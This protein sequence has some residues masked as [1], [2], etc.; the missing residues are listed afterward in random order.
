VLKKLFQHGRLDSIRLTQLD[1]TL[2]DLCNLQGG[3]ERIKNTPLPRQYEVF[4]RMLVAMYC[5][6]LPIGLVGTLGLITPIAST[7]VSFTFIT[8]ETIGRDLESPFENTVHD[9]PLTSLSNTIELNLRQHLG[10]TELPTE[11]RAV[12]GF[13]Y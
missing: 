3:C 13:V 5:I 7:V 2:V 8:L 12:H 9:T 11:V 10:E 6:M 4:P 1:S